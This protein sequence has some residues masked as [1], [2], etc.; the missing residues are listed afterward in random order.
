MA[1]T[2]DWAGSKWWKFDFHSHTPASM[3]Y[4]KGDN[5]E[6]IKKIAPS[7]WL[8]NYMRSEIDCVAVT[9]HNSGA[10]VDLLKQSFASPE[11]QE[12][13]DFRPVY[14]FPGVEISVNGGIHIL[15]IFAP[16]KSTSDIDSLLGAIDYRGNKGDCVECTQKSAIDVIKK[17]TEL[18]GIAIPAHVD[19]A[20]GMFVNEKGQ[21]LQ[22]IL[23]CTDIVAMEIVDPNNK[24]QSYICK[25]LSWAEVL[26]SDS[27][28]P[29]NTGGPNFPGSAFTWVKMSTP[30][31]EGLRLALIDGELSIQRHDTSNPSRYGGTII[32]SMSIKNAKYLG[33]ECVFLCNFNP[34]LNTII[35]GRGAGK[36]T[37]LEFLR[38]ILGCKDDLPESLIKDFEKYHSHSD[39]RQDTGLL[40]QDTSFEMI[41]RKD[42]ARFRIK[43][44][45]Y[46]QYHSIEKEIATDTWEISEGE[47]KKR[48]KT[49]IYSQKQIFESAKHPESLLRIIDDT[50]EVGYGN[51]ER[52]MDRLV[53]EYISFRTQERTILRELHEE[54]NTK[55]ILDDT[56][57]KI[58]AIEESG[59]AD[60]LQKYQKSQSQL[61]AIDSWESQWV[62]LTNSICDFA[63][64]I[65]QPHLN[66]SLFSPV[67]DEEQEFLT[68]IQ[69]TQDLVQA[70]Q[71]NLNK[72]A[73]DINAVV[74]AW[75]QDKESLRVIH[76]INAQLRSYSDLIAQLE[77]QGI[78]SP[79]ADYDNLIKLKQNCIDT[80]ESY[81]KKRS[82]LEQL[83]KKIN[84]IFQS[85]T[86]HRNRLTEQRREFLINAL[87]DN[88]DVTMEIA[89][90]ENLTN[91]EEE[92]RRLIARETGFDRCISENEDGL[93]AIFNRT[94]HSVTENIYELKIQ[95]WNIFVGETKALEKCKDKRFADYIQSLSPEQIDRLFCW[96]PEDKLKINYRFREHEFRPIEQ[97]SPGQITAALLAFILTHGDEPLILDQPEDDLDNQ[98]I[99]D[100]IVKQLRQRKIQRQ[101]IIVTHNANI[102]VNGD[103]ENI[104]ALEVSKGQTKIASQGCLQES[105][106]REKICD[107]MEGGKD[108]FDLRYRRIK[109]GII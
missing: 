28:H 64:S 15:A 35:G 95:V 26:G 40:L 58:F 66:V 98:L 70:I 16:E 97:G 56:A 42:G 24:P 12:H 54:P 9:D 72:I 96:F 79:S 78:S 3:D 5:Q 89:S 80:L 68:R 2:W 106:I 7:E 23:N 38:I 11:I 1:S 57:R 93:L 8:L 71:S 32:E 103:A 30:N 77:Q 84:E 108:A 17:I 63:R 51:W 39:N 59:H 102:V 69:T 67:I 90:M 33:R 94:E 20:R 46:D 6:E 27:H 49:Q 101:I 65:Q 14:L 99:Y 50:P 107:I 73:C 18:G 88:I 74:V 4:G 81:R 31:L 22:Q 75:Q 36:S 100:L 104:I 53:S 47:V 21:T 91:V 105:T 25:N 29:D 37:I 92:F 83:Q 19:E 61:N 55:G 43:W 76:N 48:F 13:K 87:K 85:I 44:P 41:I 62:N 10:W 45:S 86:N 34:W 60:L 109:A 82:E 52:E